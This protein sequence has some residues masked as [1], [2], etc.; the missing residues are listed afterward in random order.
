MAETSLFKQSGR[1]GRKGSNSGVS[2]KPANSLGKRNHSRAAVVSVSD[3]KAAARRYGTPDLPDDIA[4]AL[5]PFIFF[6]PDGKDML[7][8][9]DAASRLNISQKKVRA[10]I[11]KEALLAWQSPQKQDMV[12]PAE[13][14]LGEGQVVSGIDRVIEVIGNSEL[15]WEFLTAEMPFADRIA[16]PIDVLKEG[17]VDECIGSAASFGT[18]TT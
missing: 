2:F 9:S 14:I 13:Q 10:L 7:N 8:V 12:I 5:R 17:K 3:V 15:A 6:K 16:R 11:K 18:A 1:T 4:D